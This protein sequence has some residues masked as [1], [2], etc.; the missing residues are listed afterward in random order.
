MI[1]VFDSGSGGL[2]VL[3]AIKKVAPEL[4]IVYFGDLTNMPYGAKS[5][6]ELFDLTLRGFK[7]LRAAGATQLVSACNSISASVIRPLMPDEGIIEMVGPAVRELLARQVKRVAIVATP[8]TVESGIYD[9]ACAAVGIQA[10]MIACPKLAFA[11]EYDNAEIIREEVFAACEKIKAARADAILLGCTHYPFARGIFT[12]F[13]PT[14]FE[15]IDPAFAVAA[16]V[17]AKC[18][19]EGSGKLKIITSKESDNFGSRIENLFGTKPMLL[20]QNP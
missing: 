9:S 1:G 19:S 11:I 16:E 2:S 15:I 7:I 17:I 4:D 10:T 6:Q 12:E 20:G 14:N 5:P 18:G 3:V 13:L 8:A